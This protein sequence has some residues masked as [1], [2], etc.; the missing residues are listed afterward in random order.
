MR[1]LIT[2]GP[3]REYIDPV[4]FITNGSSGRMGYAVAAAALRRGHDVTL[5][6][7]PVATQ[8]PES[9]RPAAGKVARVGACRVVPFISVDGLSAAMRKHFPSADAVVMAAA[10]GDF[11]PARV[12]RRKLSRRGGPITLRL[13][14]T[15]DVLAGAA[16]GKKPGQIVLAFAVEDGPRNRA[17]A[18]ATS[19]MRR[20]NADFVLVNT[21]AAM[22]AS[23]SEACILSPS[24][25]ALPWGRRNKSALA[26][27]IVRVLEIAHE[28]ARSGTKQATCP[29][30]WCGTPGTGGRHQG[31]VRL[32]R[33]A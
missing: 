15:K 6:T 24:G 27:R 10:V 26:A 5:L 3:T 9:T 33:R 14:P 2:A 12:S 25:V 19:E 17:V 29:A 23:Q 18:K 4:R 22:G 21:P 13:V 7:G 20:K 1:I 8:P 31:P 16:A 32:S 11:R 30:E 28:Q